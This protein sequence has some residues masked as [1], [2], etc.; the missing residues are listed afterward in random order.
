MH[1]D[2]IK[3]TRL[4]R[5]VF[6]IFWFILYWVPDQALLAKPTEFDRMSALHTVFLWVER[7]YTALSHARFTTEARRSRAVS[8]VILDHSF[9]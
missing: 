1:P 3:K 4:C 7:T 2:T 6:F 5:R 9:S 8:I